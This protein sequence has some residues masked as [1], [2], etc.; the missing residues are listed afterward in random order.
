[1]NSAS[2]FSSISSRRKIVI[3]LV[4]T[5]LTLNLVQLFL[6][7]GDE[8]RLNDR[9]QSKN[10]ELV[11]TYAKLD[12]ISTELN[13]QIQILTLLNEDVTSLENVR[14]SLEREKKELRSTQ[15]MQ[16]KRYHTIKSKVGVYENLLR[17]KDEHISY[18]KK[19][20]DSLKMVNSSLVKESS[21]LKNKIDV[22]E[23]HQG[24]LEKELDEAKKL[25]AFDFNCYAVDQKGKQIIGDSFDAN[26]ISA[27]SIDFKL[28]KNVLLPSEQKTVYLCLVDPDGATIYN[29][30]EESKYFTLADTKENLFFT[31]KTN[32]NFD[33]NL[34][35]N[36]SISY[37]NNSFLNKGNYKAL[38][39]TGGYL[40]GET[41]F[42]IH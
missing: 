19:A 18:M 40:L 39:Y 16:E 30:T 34:G 15:L 17:Q 38:V 20:N 14:D 21:D 29:A 23:N 27:I 32:Y 10:I 22:L 2:F 36:V 8:K 28:A 35:A 41:K 37:Q 9:V 7:S 24:E 42:T 25:N 5:L 31:T 26:N 4:I 11:L 33:S 3:G 13:K 12:S 1:M 6:R